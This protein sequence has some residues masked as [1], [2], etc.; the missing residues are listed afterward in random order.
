[1]D[2]GTGKDLDEYVLDGDQIP[3]HLIDI[4][5]PGYKYNIAEFQLD[6]LNA[7][8]L[9][10]NRGKF[11]I[12][13]G[14]S[15]LY[16]ET[17]LRGN[18]FLGIPPDEDR[19]AI[20]S[21]LP[22]AEIE[23]QYNSLPERLKKKLSATTLKRKVRA[24]IIHEYLVANPSWKSR[25]I[26]AFH[27]LIIGVNIDR[28]LRRKK[29]TNRLRF[30]LDH[31]MIEEVEELIDVYGLNRDQLEYYGLEYKWISSFLK[32]EVNRDELFEKLNVAIHQFAKRQMTWFR[33][34]EKNGFKIEWINA[35]DSDESK[36]RRVLSLLEDSY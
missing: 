36:I 8:E 28:E 5:P 11:P 34:M 15:G 20:L 30:R 13:C 21:S 17:A 19:E 33:R 7:F 27:P 24:I 25:E 3:Y 31:G 16:I 22:K 18:S 2:I 10:Q 29:I 4:R 35:E 26:P 23:E 9:I 1:M 32:G 6:S 12:L 14:G